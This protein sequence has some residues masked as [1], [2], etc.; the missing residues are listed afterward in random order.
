MVKPK[1]LFEVNLRKK[2]K[3][4]KAKEC[5]DTA[6]L[7]QFIDEQCVKYT[8][9]ETVEPFLF[10]DYFNYGRSND[11]IKEF[12]CTT[13]SNKTLIAAVINRSLQVYDFMLGK[14]LF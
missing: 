6:R 10:Y 5:F 4:Y 12:E 7:Y 13:C 9:I 11:Y 14:L 3:L 8:K 1:H 2:D